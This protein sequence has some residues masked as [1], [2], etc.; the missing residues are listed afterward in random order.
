[1]SVI[2]A[3]W[4]A[5]VSRRISG[6]KLAPV[7]TLALLPEKQTKAGGVTQAVQCYLA[8]TRS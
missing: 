8:S 1:M 2:P 3:M 4:E 6:S 7:K 5:W